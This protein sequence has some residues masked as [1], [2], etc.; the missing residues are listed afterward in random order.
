M[1]IMRRLQVAAIASMTV[2]VFETLVR[3]GTASFSAWG[4]SSR[5][6]HIQGIPVWAF[7]SIQ[8]KQG[9]RFD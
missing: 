1:A 6:R 9:V 2:E 7:R 3:P 5:V 8:L 4:Y